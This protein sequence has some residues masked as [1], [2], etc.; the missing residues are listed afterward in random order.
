M[1]KGL[2]LAVVASMLVS[3]NVAMAGLG[4]PKAPGAGKPAASSSQEAVDVGALMER[5]Q[6]ILQ[7]LNVA[8]AAA[9]LLH[10][11]ITTY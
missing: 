11:Q 9:D 2:A 10:G 8:Q 4:V 7:Y 1:K 5:N 6:P 3:A